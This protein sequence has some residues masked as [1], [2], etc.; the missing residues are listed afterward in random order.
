MASIDYQEARR[1]IVRMFSAQDTSG[2]KIIFW[3]DAPKVFYEDVKAD[4]FDCCR[5]LI[6]DRNEF[7]IKKTIE[8]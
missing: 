1:E 2:R 6:C 8:R 7:T 3:Y 4:A 5:V